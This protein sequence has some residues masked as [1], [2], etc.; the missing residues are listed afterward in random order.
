[1]INMK[2]EIEQLLPEN[3]SQSLSKIVRLQN[4]V[5]EGKHT[6]K[7][8]KIR[9]WYLD[10]PLGQVISFNAFYGDEIV[11]HYACIPYKMIIKGQEV[12]GL[13]D[14]ATVTHPEHRG[15]GLFKKLAKITYDYAQNRGYQFVLGVANGN[16]YPGYMKYFPFID[17]GKLDVKIGLGSNLYSNCRNHPVY[18]FWSLEA[19]NWRI[20]IREE[21]NYW[22][23]GRLLFG[24]IKVPFFKLLMGYFDDSVLPHQLLI[25]KI[26]S[27]LNPFNLY[28]GLGAD[29]KKG[30]Y[31]NVPKWVKHSPF[32]L[33]FM[34]LTDGELPTFERED[35]FFQLIDFDVA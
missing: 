18:V 1:M 23:H 35:I 10:N 33:I 30:F 8:E 9:K 26:R 14:M 15:K 27:W 32:H 17:Y 3:M 25:S 6:F 4:I 13:L 34:D 19:L 11:A 5:Y 20:G 16:S 29:T 24:K 2:Y 31:I 12:I 21:G 22:K 28:I 7:V